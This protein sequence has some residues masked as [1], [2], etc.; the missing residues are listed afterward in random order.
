[1]ESSLFKPNLHH[2]T[3][4][5]ASH[6]EVRFLLNKDWRLLWQ[7]ELTKAEFS[8]TKPE[9]ATFGVHLVLQSNTLSAQIPLLPGSPPRPFWATLCL[10]LINP[11]SYYQSYSPGNQLYMAWSLDHSWGFPGGSEG[12]ASACNVGDLGSL[13][14]TILVILL[15]TFE[16]FYHLKWSEVKVAS[17]SSVTQSC[18]TLCHLMDCSTPCFPVC[19]L[20]SPRACSNSCPLSRWC[21]PTIWSSVVPFSSCPQSFPASRSFPMSQLFTS[22]GQSIGASASVLPITIQGGFP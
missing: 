6:S 10:L 16:F 9:P 3:G 2:Q 20:P 4:W 5:L 19:P 18:P 14:K 11:N 21:H 1:M 8:Q 17:I 12:K 22:G 13:Y 15:W 7:K